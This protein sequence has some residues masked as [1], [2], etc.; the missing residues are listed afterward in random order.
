MSGFAASARIFLSTFPLRGTSI[1]CDGLPQR[2]SSISIHVPLAGN[3]AA[4]SVFWSRPRH[5][6]P[7]S[8]CG[9]RRS[10][11]LSRRGWRNFYPRSP[12]GERRYI[13]KKLLDDWIFLSTFPLR[14]TSCE[15][16]VRRCGIQI[17][18]H[19]PL[20]GNVARAG[21]H[22]HKHPISIHVPLAGNVFGARAHGRIFRNFYP[23][24]P[25]GERLSRPF[26]AVYNHSI[27][28]HV[29]LAGNVV[30]TRLTEARSFNFYPRSPCGERLALE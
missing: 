20:A 8:P 29:P 13:Y 21:I 9:E 3:V 28:I 15:R 17:S 30:P 2:Q 16:P 25:C 10:P 18:I 7:R 12:C 19:V 24:S 14:G 1:K 5:F 4:I 23:R 26:Q 22:Q 11:G 6:Y 27:S